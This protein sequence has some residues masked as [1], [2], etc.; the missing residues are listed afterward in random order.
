MKT[1]NFREALNSMYP[2]EFPVIFHKSTEIFP[3]SETLFIKKQDKLDVIYENDCYIFILTRND[4]KIELAKIQTEFY[5]DVLEH[6]KSNL[7]SSKTEKI[8]YKQLIA[9]TQIKVPDIIKSKIQNSMNSENLSYIIRS[10]IYGNIE[11]YSR[12]NLKSLNLIN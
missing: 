5:N 1:L 6:L 8:S 4:N 12:K 11:L 10:I 3:R 7:E 9:Q 2:F